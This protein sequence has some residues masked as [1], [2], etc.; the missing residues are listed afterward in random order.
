MI[1]NKR[2]D[3]LTMFENQSQL[4]D[5]NTSINK[6]GPETCEKPKED[7][8]RE[9]VTETVVEVHAEDPKSKE[10]TGMAVTICPDGLLKEVIIDRVHYAITPLNEPKEASVPMSVTVPVSSAKHSEIVDEVLII[11]VVKKRTLGVHLSK[12][13]RCISLKEFQNLMR[14]KEEAK[15]KE[16]EEMED[17]K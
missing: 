14:E 11:P 17:H 6:G 1:N 10:L 3:P 16:E 4:P 9:N 5:V 7:T 12:I 8:R 15:C 2:L 13:L